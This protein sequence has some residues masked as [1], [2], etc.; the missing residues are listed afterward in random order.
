MGFSQRHGLA[1]EIVAVAHEVPEQPRSVEV[2]RDSGLTAREKSRPL[3]PVL[4]AELLKR[5][6]GLSEV[7]GGV[8]GVA[9][10][11]HRRG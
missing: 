4:D 2:W 8:G 3:H 6:M 5:D 1:V 9:R 10:T 11:A 7:P